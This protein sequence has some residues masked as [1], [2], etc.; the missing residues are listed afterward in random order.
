MHVN[1]SD[2]NAVVIRYSKVLILSTVR[3]QSMGFLGMDYLNCMFKHT[4]EA[5]KRWTISQV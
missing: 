1:V 2:I 5:H 4:G 3:V